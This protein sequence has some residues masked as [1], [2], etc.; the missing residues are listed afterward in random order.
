MINFLLLIASTAM[1][2]LA[3]T[4]MKLGGQSLTFDAGVI[5]ILKGYMLSPL[6][7]AGFVSYFLGALLWIYCLS[8]FDLSFASFVSSLQYVFLLLASIFIFKEQI[9]VNQW[10]GCG[11]I[12]VGV[13]F[14]MRG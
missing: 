12:M 5:G 13:I 11:C 10:I 7:M 14:W 2:A 6:I 1:A 8:Q 4:L 9:S 3:G